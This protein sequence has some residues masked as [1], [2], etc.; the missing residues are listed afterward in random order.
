MLELRALPPLI[1]KFFKSDLNSSAA[2]RRYLRVNKWTRNVNLFKKDFLIVPINKN[3][4]WYLAIICYPYLAEPVFKDAIKHENSFNDENCS[5]EPAKLTNQETKESNSS[6]KNF[7]K[8]PKQVDTENL[9]LDSDSADEADEADDDD[10]D[11]SHVFTKLNK[12]ANKV[13]V[14]M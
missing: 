11:Y 5:N 13:C 6:V 12:N 2:E 8:N 3:A 9:K 4:H 10:N 1:G 14:K 7:Y